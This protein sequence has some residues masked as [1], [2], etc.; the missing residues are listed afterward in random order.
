MI[1]RQS[2]HLVTQQRNNFV[3]CFLESQAISK[4]QAC[5]CQRPKTHN[6]Q[7]SVASKVHRCANL[8]HD[9]VAMGSASESIWLQPT[10]RFMF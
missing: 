2:V 7:N 10:D 8:R 9:S 4:T 1:C 6:C 5:W 3:K